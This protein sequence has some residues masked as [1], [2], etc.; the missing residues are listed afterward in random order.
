M[1]QMLDGL[2]RSIFFETC[3][4][5]SLHLLAS[6]QSFKLPSPSHFFVHKNACP[7]GDSN[8]QPLAL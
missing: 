8:L 2:A 7:S 6:H 1:K 4:G 3:V 5:W